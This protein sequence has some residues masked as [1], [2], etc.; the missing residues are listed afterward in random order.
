MMPVQ[1]CSI[2]TGTIVG[3]GNDAQPI[4]DG[5]CCGPPPRERVI[6]ERTL[7]ILEQRHQAKWQRRTNV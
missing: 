1:A 3:L 7:R 4:N 2:C 5:R 6:P